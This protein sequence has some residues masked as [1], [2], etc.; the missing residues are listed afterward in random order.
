MVLA[1]I[2]SAY[3]TGEGLTLYISLQRLESSRVVI[4]ELI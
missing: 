2:S 3:P 1:A 4:R